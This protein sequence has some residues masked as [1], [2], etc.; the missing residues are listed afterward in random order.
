MLKRLRFKFVVINMSIVTLMLCFILVL[1]Y[2]F[3]SANLENESIRMMQSIA[4]SPP[5]PVPD[6]INEDVRLPFFTLQLGPHGELVGVQGGYYDLSD[7]DVLSDLVAEATASPRLLGVIDAYNLRYYRV[8]S[9]GRDLLVF[10]DISS[11]RATLDGLMRTCVA[12]G[13]AGFL[14]FLGISIMLS[15]WAVK[16]VE[17]SWK[18]QREFVAAAS[19]ELKTPLTVVMTNAELLAS[20]ETGHERQVSSILTMSCR[21]RRLI[22]QLLELARAEDEGEGAAFAAVDLSRLAESV[23]LTMEPVYFEKGLQLSTD[24]AANVPVAGDEAQLRELLEILL[25]NAGKY[26]EPGGKVRI[27]LG[28]KGRGRCQLA[29]ENAGTPIPQEELES[30]F[31]RFYRAEGARREK[32]GFGLGLSIARGIAERHGGKIWA[33]SGGGLNRFIVELPVKN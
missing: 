3:T 9:A 8:F 23:S 12:I 24:I 28:R 20:S 17:R 15:K 22:E 7:Y 14:L 2:Y 10:S 16:P 21:M 11:E 19:H 27:T 1:V 29:V 26:S 31:K 30:I 13:V 33:E 6:E 25:D 18:Q 4:L 5:Q 32:E